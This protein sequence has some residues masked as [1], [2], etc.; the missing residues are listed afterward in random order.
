MD[1]QTQ[2][3]LTLF[4]EELTALIY[5]ALAD[6]PLSTTDLAQATGTD[7]RVLGTHLKTM[8]LSGLVRSYK[9]PKEGPGRP[10]I[11]WEL[12][13]EELVG[14]FCELVKGIRHRFIDS[15]ADETNR[16]G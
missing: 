14:E 3:F 8:K 16:D 15:D 5:G 11:Y 9:R 7:P 2:A 4:S 1:Q 6:E 13:N 10:T 12:S